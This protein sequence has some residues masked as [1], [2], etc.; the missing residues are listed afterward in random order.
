VEQ[1]ALNVRLVC[2][3]LL[4]IAGLSVL[5]MVAGAATKHGVAV[6][7]AAATFAFAISLAAAAINFEAWRRLPSA[8]EDTAAR[9][10]IG[11]L[12]ANGSLLTIAYGWGALAMQAVYLKPVTGLWWQHCWQYA[13]VML[14]LAVASAAFVR[15]A[16]H[17]VADAGGNLAAFPLLISRPLAMA[18]GAVATGGLAFLALSG[19]LAASRADWAANRV[20]AALAVAVLA[21]SLATLATRTR[22]EA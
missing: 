7:A 17:A 16:G 14:L 6:S 2:Y 12:V 11:A 8:D 3:L 20:F 10:A 15:R 1:R 18:Q 9:I 5:A 4:A 22:P 19:K 21:V 13:L